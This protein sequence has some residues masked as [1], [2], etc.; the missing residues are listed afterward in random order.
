MAG[1]SGWP[2]WAYK[3]RILG[4]FL[5]GDVCPSL[6]CQIPRAVPGSQYRTVMMRFLLSHGVAL[7]AMAAGVWSHAVVDTPSPRKVRCNH[8]RSHRVDLVPGTDSKSTCLSRRVLCKS[9]FVGPPLL[10][11]SSEV[12]GLTARREPLSKFRHAAESC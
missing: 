12:G 6:Q 5:S 10:K 11:L 9:S 1:N 7:A 3:S 4:T 8:L 2:I